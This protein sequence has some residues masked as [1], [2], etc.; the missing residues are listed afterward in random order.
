MGNVSD[1]VTA[2]LL[3]MGAAV[4]HAS[5]KLAV[6]Q[7]GARYLAIWGQFAAAGVIGHGSRVW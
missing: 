3:A 1:V 7:S 5:W 4:L 2:T 6:K